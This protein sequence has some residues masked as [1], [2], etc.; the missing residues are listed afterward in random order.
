EPH[1]RN[2]LTLL[3]MCRSWHAL[4]KLRMHTNET[5]NLLD[6]A[7]ATLGKQLRHFQKITCLA[8]KTHELKREAERRQR[9]KLRNLV[10]SREAVATES[11]PH[12][13]WRP[14]TFNLQTYKLHALGDY[15]T[16]IRNFG[17]TDSY[18]TELGELEHCTSKARYR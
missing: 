2:V 7:T 16:A 9:Q 1:N 18:S 5:L 14:K 8:F 12:T 11:T 6:V 17:T 15:S 3:S 13:V 10:G 4:A